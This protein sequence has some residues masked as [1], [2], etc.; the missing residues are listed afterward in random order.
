MS[1]G[2]D[3]DGCKIGGE[4]AACAEAKSFGVPVSP[5]GEFFWTFTFKSTD[6]TPGSTGHIKFLYVDDELDKK[7]DFRKTG[8][9]G[10]FDVDLQ[11]PTGTPDP[12]GV[13]EPATLALFGMAVAASA[14]RY[15]RPRRQ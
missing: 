11:R 3:A 8:G 2:L 13:P 15:Y 12:H 5:S 1:S 9:L 10:S 4:L 7:G 6:A 14:R